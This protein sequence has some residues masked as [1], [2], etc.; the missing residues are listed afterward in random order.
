M[1]I[2]GNPQVIAV[3][4]VPGPKGFCGA[5]LWLAGAS[6]GDPDLYGTAGSLA[7]G[8][9]RFR[10]GALE[11]V[12]PIL[13]NE[14]ALTL[15]DRVHNALFGPSKDLESSVANG[16]RYG[17]LLL[18]PNL[19]ECLDDFMIVVVSDRAEQRVLVRGYADGTML[20]AR[21][22]D[23]TLEEVFEAAEELLWGFDCQR[24]AESE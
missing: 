19:C 9:A 7:E 4:L 21:V 15:L 17:A 2:C 1:T 6:V 20:E 24:D 16:R 23:G 11:R 22:P 5:R 14:P 13:F 3:E 8:L 12:Q 10:A 18:S